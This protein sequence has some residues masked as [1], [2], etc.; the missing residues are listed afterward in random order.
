MDQDASASINA[1]ELVALTSKPCKWITVIRQAGTKSEI[2]RYMNRWPVFAVMVGMFIVA[3]PGDQ[4]WY[5]DRL[6]SGGFY[7]KVHD[8]YN[9]AEADCYDHVDLI[10]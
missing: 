6:A 9:E 10:R 8:T 7:A 3:I 2:E 4:A 5:A 1:S